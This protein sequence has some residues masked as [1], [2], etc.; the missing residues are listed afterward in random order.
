MKKVKT[1]VAT[2]PHQEKLVE[3]LD[4]PNSPIIVVK[5]ENNFFPT[6]GAHRLSENNFTSYK[7]A[8]E[9]CNTS[10]INFMIQLI[11]AI[12]HYTYINLQNNK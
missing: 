5:M 12:T 6:L 3:R 2:E 4:V 10:N 7:S 8:V 9:Y 1:T 11:A